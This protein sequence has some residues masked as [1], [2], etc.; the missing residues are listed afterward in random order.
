MSKGVHTCKHWSQRYISE[1]EVSEESG[2]DCTR[3]VTDQGGSC[4]NCCREQN[5]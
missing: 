5:L 1:D 4:G 2:E 3:S